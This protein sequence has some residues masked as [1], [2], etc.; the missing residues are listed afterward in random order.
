[1]HIAADIAMIVIAVA[2]MGSLVYGA[3]QLTSHK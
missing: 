1:M 2:F 3:M